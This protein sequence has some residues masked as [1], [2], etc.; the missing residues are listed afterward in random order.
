MQGNRQLWQLL[1][2]GFPSREVVDAWAPPNKRTDR[3]F[4]MQLTQADT[5]AL[6]DASRHHQ[7][8]VHAALLAA[9]FLALHAEYPSPKPRTMGQLSLV[10]LRQRSTP[11]VPMDAMAPCI[12]FTSTI[13][14][15][16]PLESFWT[17][18]QEIQREL[19][20]Q[21]Q[22]QDHWLTLPTLA[23]IV[24]R[25]ALHRPHKQSRAARLFQRIEAW[26]PKVSLLSNVGSLDAILPPASEGPLQLRSMGFFFAL[27]SSG[28]IGASATTFA[29]QLHWNWTYAHPTFSPT[30]AR[31]IAQRAKG[32]LIDAIEQKASSNRPETASIDTRK[33]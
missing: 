28:R 9:Q 17:L 19:T 14:R 32:Y 26:G 3:F 5:T 27:S 8:T 24:H 6:R 11:P 29:G 15:I 22:H 30:R 23:T 12:S 25:Q 4:P 31:R 7:T 16:H 33:G 2:K 18:A 21:L 1:R 13:H 20:G 10:S